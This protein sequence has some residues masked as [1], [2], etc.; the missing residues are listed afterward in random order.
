MKPGIRF[1]VLASGSRG[2]AC[3]VATEKA[4][5]LIDAGL[6]CRELERR[7]QG[8]GVD[9]GALNALILTHEHSDHV[10]GAGP[11]LRR[12]DL[13]LF[14]NPKTLQG[15]RKALGNISRPVMIQTGQTFAL[16]G[17]SIDT[18]TKCHDARDPFGIVIHHE[19]VR[20]GIVTDLGRSTHLLQDRLKGCHA[21]I[22]EFN[23]D[24]VM[25]QDGPY[26]L[27]LKRRIKG[28]EGHLSNQQARD[29]LC[30]L[31]HEKL[32][33]LIPAHISETNNHPDTAQRMAREALDACGLKKTR[34]LVSRQNESLPL[35][36]L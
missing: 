6:S 26:P 19:G 27:E 12:Y 25:L 16:N 8:L 35:I 9:P 34:I 28:S 23:H 14:T 36:E 3:Y 11:L 33:I 24:P 30:T 17:L 32:Q 1:S 2:N 22:L 21:L 13:P 10:R 18:F 31:A 5:I 20:I 29:L 15:A 7:L 4:A